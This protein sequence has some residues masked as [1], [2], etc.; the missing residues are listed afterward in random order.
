MS[1]VVEE[2]EKGVNQDEHLWD[3]DATDG[4]PSSIRSSH[5]LEDV[6]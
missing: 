1:G 2:D 6:I 4:L 5:W 3:V